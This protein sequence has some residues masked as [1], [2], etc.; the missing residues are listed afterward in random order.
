MILM[1]TKL[2]MLARFCISFSNVK[3][4]SLVMIYEHP[5]LAK[6]KDRK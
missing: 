1:E 5:H 6:Y 2:P 3:I 4:K